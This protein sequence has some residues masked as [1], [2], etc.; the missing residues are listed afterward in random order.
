MSKLLFCALARAA[1]GWSLVAGAAQ[2]GSPARQEASST[3]SLTAS[4]LPGAAAAPADPEEVPGAETGAPLS[5]P[6]ILCGVVAI[7]AIALCFYLCA[8]WTR[9]DKSVR[10]SP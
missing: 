6:V 8:R 5:L 1:V 3:A 7:G 2:A 10:P 9:T 4:N